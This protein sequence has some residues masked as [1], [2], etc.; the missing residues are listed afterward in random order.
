MLKTIFLFTMHYGKRRLTPTRRRDYSYLRHSHAAFA[1]P[2]PR[3][4]D[5]L[6]DSDL[7]IFSAKFSK[8]TFLVRTLVCFMAMGTLAACGGGGT[9]SAPV[10][11]DF[12][13]L[14]KTVGDAPFALSAPVSSDPTPFTYTSDNPAVAT[15]S[16]A[17]VTIVAAGTTKITALQLKNNFPIVSKSAL[18]TVAAA[19]NGQSTVARTLALNLASGTP[20]PAFGS[21]VISA[22]VTSNGIPAAAT[23]ISF[24]ASCGSLNPATV[25]SDASS[26]AA[27]TTYTANPAANDGC[28]GASVTITASAT[29]L[30]PASGSITVQP[31]LATNLQFVGAS[32]SLLYLAG[33]AGPGATQGLVTFRA[34]DAVGTPLGKQSV[35]LSLT[36]LAAGV[37]IGAPNSQA[38]VTLA[39]G[40]NGQV[41]VPVFSGAIP[42]SVQ[43]RATLA[44]QPE[45][46]ADSNA[47]IIA[48]GVPAQKFT[49]LSIEKFSIEGLTTDGVSSVVAFSL[50]DRQGN[51]VPVGTTVNFVASHGVMV[52]AT[53]TV[54]ALADGSSASSCTS[55]IRSQGSRPA[56]GKV[57]ILAYATG[58]EDFV[59]LNGNNVY[60]P[61]EPFTDLGAAYRDDDF[62]L[63]Y[64]PGEFVVPRLPKNGAYVNCAGAAGGVLGQ[65]NTCD[66]VWGPIEV[67]GQ[68]TVI[69]ATGAAYFSNI[70]SS[71]GAGPKFTISDSAN[72]G[73]SMPTGTRITVAVVDAVPTGC[74][75]T[76]LP[77]V[78]PN[79]TDPITIAITTGCLANATLLINTVS[80]L[81]ITSAF[82]MKLGN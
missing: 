3:K 58:E 47:L 55:S 68:R 8:K 77:A 37:A 42:S 67:R 9:V 12:P 64:T 82:T 23:S 62:S 1:T 60:D 72:T 13:A 10:S 78:V 27:S 7:M 24:T 19:A 52:P 54:P 46:K 16:G 71:I 76:V 17:T 31:A 50:A 79:T 30:A 49:S 6:T 2:V 26:G 43:V 53:C 22:T 32:P 4:M 29:G 39:T 21:R 56:D 61:G 59:D 73:N 25:T 75:A 34:V 57:V 38:P 14:N 48:S 70:V 40:S 74:S 41:T 20:L 5:G 35:I 44:S 18:L 63:S 11:D 36:N 28:G 33:A 51:P 69:F 66:G 45:I 81:G 80:P 65:A 15:I